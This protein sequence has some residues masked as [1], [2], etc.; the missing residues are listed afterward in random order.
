MLLAAG[1]GLRMRPVTLE[2]PKPLIEVAGRTLL[3]RALDRLE[4]A[5]VAQVVVNVHHLGQ[6]IIQRLEKR[7]SPKIIISEEKDLLETGGGI[8]KA[9]PHLGDGPFF[10]VNSDALWLNGP[11]DAL[12]RLAD[13]WDERRMDG[14]LLLHA[15]ADAY[16]YSGMGDFQMDSMGLISRRSERECSPFLFTGIQIIHPRAFENIPPRAFSLN[17][18][19]S[20]MIDAKRLYGV[21]HDGEWFHAGTPEGLADADAYMRAHGFGQTI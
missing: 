21:R 19:F 7:P 20:R 4:A 15:T 13:L 8:A 9:L 3:D 11:E 6:V 12:Q 18:L 16:G 1:L 10:T 5:G 14:L 17:L 2:L